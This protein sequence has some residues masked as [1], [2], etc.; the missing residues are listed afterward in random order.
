VARNNKS[1]SDP[2]GILKK[3]GELEVSFPNLKMPE[4]E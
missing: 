3:A 1:L 4:A 2:E